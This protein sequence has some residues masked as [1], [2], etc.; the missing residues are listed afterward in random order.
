MER[1]DDVA[2]IR[3]KA[4]IIRQDRLPAK[5]SG[6]GHKLAAGPGGAGYARKCTSLNPLFFLSYLAPRNLHCTFSM[7][8][9][10]LALELCVFT[11]CIAR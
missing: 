3:P 4:N 5:S 10:E 2:D 8:Y 11:D 7:I 9:K 6:Q 1:T